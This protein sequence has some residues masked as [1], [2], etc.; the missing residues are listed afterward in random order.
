LHKITEF[1]ED[2]GTIHELPVQEKI[3]EKIVYVEKEVPDKSSEEI[4]TIHEVSIQEK[5][6]DISI[7]DV[8]TNW[9]DIVNESKRRKMPLISFLSTATPTKIED[10]ILHIGFY[11]ENRFHKES[12]E[13]PYYN[14]IFL[15]VLKEKFGGRV[16][17]KYD[18]LNEKNKVVE[19]KSDFVERV[20]DF[21]DGELI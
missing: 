10:G 11:A 4:G 12:M 20:V 6:V 5:T 21:F 17:V 1:K 15:E 2:V 7:E 19:D 3:V 8:R 18:L 16:M 14:D 9:N 13:K